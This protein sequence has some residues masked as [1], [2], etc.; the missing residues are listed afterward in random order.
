MDWWW[1]GA[2]GAIKHRQETG[3]FPSKYQ[4][5]ALIV[6]VTGMSG[7]SLADMLQLAGTPGGRWKVYGVACRPQPEWQFHHRIH[8]IQCEMADP[9]DSQAKLSRL[10]DVTHVFYVGWVNKSSEDESRVE[11]GNML[12]NVLKAVIPNAPN[13]Q[14][15]CL[16]TGQNSSIPSA[17]VG[18]SED[19]ARADSLGCYS[20]MENILSE[21][22]RNKENL[23]WSIHRP[24][25]M[26]GF[27]PYS[28]RNIVGSLCVYATIC[29]HEKKPLRFPGIQAAWD[30]YSEGADADL[31]A[32]QQIWAGLERPG[33][34][35][36][37]NCS[38]GDKFK[39]RDLWKVLAEEFEVE[40]MEFEE[41]SET[42]EEM[43]RDKG[44]V[45]DEIVEEKELLP[46]KLEELGTWWYVDY[47]I[48]R[49]P[50]S[51]SDVSCSMNKS[52]EYGF[53][54]SRDTVESFRFWIEHTRKYK[55]V[56]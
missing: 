43:M 8:Y 45:W 24:S 37:F 27:S 31:V 52:K 41:C 12:R 1:R 54:G 32:D 23:T 33:K 47:V 9:Q 2:A 21:E 25:V 48:R 17:N 50:G 51:G 34:G 53:D 30:G 36:V 29:K 44:P 55:I 39:W 49:E 14:H 3:D 19:L 20:G 13:L 5:V 26:I 56:P 35:Q 42:L 40:Y 4:N 7:N 46:T 28:T 15:I 22:V 6:G 38:N 18:F 10:T 16:Q 11:N